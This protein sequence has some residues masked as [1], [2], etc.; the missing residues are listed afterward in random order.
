V[1]RW[2]QTALEHFLKARIVRPHLI[3]LLFEQEHLRRVFN[4]FRIDCVFDVG[5]HEGEYAEMIRARAG[6]AGPIISFEPVAEAA[7]ILRRKAARHRTWFVEQIA[8][9]E[10]PGIKPFNIMA[11]TQ[12]SSFHTPD[13]AD[14]TIFAG[15]NSILQS[16]PVETST[17]QLQYEK[18]RT[19]LQF[20]RPFLKV[21]TQGHDCAVIAGAGTALAN[22]VGL[23]SELS[24][25]R[26]YQETPEMSEAL[27]YF[28]DRGFVLS[29]LV[30]N[31][32]GHFPVLVEID[33]IMINFSALASS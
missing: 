33:C 30:P 11:D 6:Y 27:R 8:L 23:Q 10:A 16:V 25:R 15:K 18:Y 24:V 29:A 31:N 5:A 12:F 28:Q 20:K 14:L 9:D 2:I 26:I 3:G 4:E 19:N 13:N 1:K 21:D 7:E 32:A 22:F 17:L